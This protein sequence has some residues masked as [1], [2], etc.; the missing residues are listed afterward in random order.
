MVTSSFGLTRLRR[1]EKRWVKITDKE[2]NL[3]SCVLDHY[4][5]DEVV[6]IKIRGKDVVIT[7]A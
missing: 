4:E 3:C 6:F 7:E 2:I 5:G 1:V